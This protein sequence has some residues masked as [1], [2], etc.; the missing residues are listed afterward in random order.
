MFVPFLIM[1][2]EGLEAALIVSLIASY[3]KRTQRGQWM[4]AVWVG[5]VVAV[6]LCLAIGIFINE[7]TG[8]FPQKQ[9]ELFEGIIAVVAVCIL[10]YMVF[11]MRKVS[12]SVKVHLEGAIDNALN[13][14]RGQGWALVAMVFFAVA[15]EGLE[16]VFFLLAAFQQDVGIGAPIGAILGLVCAILVGMAIYWGG[17]KLHLAKFFKWTSLFILFVAAGLAA[18]AIRA[19]H[20]AGLWNHFQDIAFDLTDVLSTH[21]LLGTFLEGMFGYQEAPTVSVVSVYFI[22]LI[23]ALILFFLPPRSTA[24]S[25]IAAARKINP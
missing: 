20:E 8:E 24:G 15:R 23:P 3:L 10:T 17:V 12:K 19:F 14:G 13:S 7:T 22:Y 4:G 21:S 9:Q 6:V 18:G 2:R 5:V 25:A 16:S 11:W 1:F